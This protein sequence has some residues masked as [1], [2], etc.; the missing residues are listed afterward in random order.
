MHFDRERKKHRVDVMFSEH[1]A[2]QLA[3][4]SCHQVCL[5]A[6]GKIN[7]NK[8]AP[9]ALHAESGLGQRAVKKWVG[10]RTNPAAEHA[11][12]VTVE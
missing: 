4:P 6:D 10:S 7:G 2:R 5:E 12:S 9:A 8:L 11:Y 3:K 1:V